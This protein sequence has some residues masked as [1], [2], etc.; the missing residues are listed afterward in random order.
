MGTTVATNALLERKG[1]AT[2]LVTSSGF[3]DVLQIGN[4]S[5]PRIFDLTLAK[6]SVIYERTLETCAR[7][8]FHGR[9]KLQPLSPDSMLCRCN[10][11]TVHV[12]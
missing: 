5:R 11:L 4:Q 3:K 12:R 6:A 8:R 9:E 10:T 1:Q 2:L 7:V